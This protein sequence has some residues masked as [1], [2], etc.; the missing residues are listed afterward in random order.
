MSFWLQLALQILAMAFVFVFSIF[1]HEL[2][3]ALVGRWSGMSVT[4][5][6]VG[7]SRPFVRWR[8]WGIRVYLCRNLWWGG[9]TYYLPPTLFGSRTARILTLAGG[10][11]F[12]L[13][14]V[15]LGVLAWWLFPGA[16]MVLSF[17]VGINLLLFLTASWPY[18]VKLSGGVLLSDGAQIINQLQGKLPD[19]SA[20]QGIESAY[21]LSK[22]FSDAGDHLG[23]LA[24]DVAL[25][26]YWIALGDIKGSRERWQQMEP[27][28]LEA[29]G[30]AKAIYLLLWQALAIEE[31]HFDE[32]RQ[33]LE[34][35]HEEI[36]AWDEPDPDALWLVQMLEVELLLE[37]DAFPQAEAKLT[38]IESLRPAPPKSL[39][40]LHALI[41]A[42]KRLHKDAPPSPPE[43]WTAPLDPDDTSFFQIYAAAAERAASQGAKAQARES[44]KIFLK[45]WTKLLHNLHTP[46]FRQKMLMLHKEPIEAALDRLDP[47]EDSELIEQTKALQAWDGEGRWPL[48]TTTQEAASKGMRWL[49][50]ALI[51]ASV[52]VLTLTVQSWLIPRQKQRVS[53]WFTAHHQSQV[54]CK[55]SRSAWQRGQKEKAKRLA[56]AALKENRD[57]A[58]RCYNSLYR[59]WQKAQQTKP[60]LALATDM[61]SWKLAKQHQV[62]LRLWRVH[63]FMGQKKLDSATKEYKRAL[64]ESALMKAVV[65]LNWARLMASHHKTKE[66]VQA[67]QS[68]AKVPHSIIPTLNVCG[69]LLRKLKR[70]KVLQQLCH[71]AHQK[72]RSSP[73]LQSICPSQSPH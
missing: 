1:V 67:C 68:A 73:S 39:L 60:I 66:V 18:K 71:K 62:L 17:L 22:L 36:A 3:H 29:L 21:F 28:S 32:A 24:Q 16:R 15:G 54:L 72:G 30:S 49:R 43:T 47:A 6:G 57:L 58:I 64:Q 19:I 59:S 70:P 14:F 5:F 46:A 45:H 12:N 33:A 44:S 40:R 37:S 48:A 7:S 56:Q 31:Q 11:L 50:L 13:L 41:Q 34:A 25:A 2:G 65:H 8:W 61:L 69:P 35:L 53:K 20:T 26:Y 27:E 55:R 63:A 9:L 42:K 52:F 10:L 4:S 51:F 38:S 23:A